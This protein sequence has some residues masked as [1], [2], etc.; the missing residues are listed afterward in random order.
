MY[1][2]ASATEPAGTVVRGVARRGTSYRASSPVRYPKPGANPQ[3]ATVNEA[4]VW[5]RT[6]AS[7]DTPHSAATSARSGPS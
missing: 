6:A 5:I 3:N 2:P 1:G 4:S 7:G